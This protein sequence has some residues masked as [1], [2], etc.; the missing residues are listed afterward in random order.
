MI[1][2]SAHADRRA[3]QRGITSSLIAR[4]LEHADVEKPIGDGCTLVGVSRRTARSDR[5]AEGLDR[6]RLIESGHNGQVVTAMIVHKG[7]SGRRYRRG[8]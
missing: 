5:R 8:L 3:R 6:Y 4:I 1:G 2:I 7:R